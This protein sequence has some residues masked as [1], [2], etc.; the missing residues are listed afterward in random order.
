MA[1]YGYAVFKNYRASR[2]QSGDLAGAKEQRCGDNMRP[3]YRASQPPGPRDVRR[4]SRA[5]TPAPA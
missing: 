3:P 1:E 4:V 2:N 5:R